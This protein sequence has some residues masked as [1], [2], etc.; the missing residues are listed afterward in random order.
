MDRSTMA[1]AFGSEA[2]SRPRAHTDQSRPAP[3][4]A[5]DDAGNPLEEVRLEKD[6]WQDL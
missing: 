6:Q 3:H 2:L 4:R 5:S 1:L